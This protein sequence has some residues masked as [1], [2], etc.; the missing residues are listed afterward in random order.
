MMDLAMSMLM[1]RCARCHRRLLRRPPF[2]FFFFFAMLFPDMR[3]A[4]AKMRARPVRACAAARPPLAPPLIFTPSFLRLRHA[5]FIAFFLLA[6]AFTPASPRH[7]ARYIAR[8]PRR[9]PCNM[10]GGVMRAA[11][12]APKRCLPPRCERHDGCCLLF[13]AI[14]PAHAH[15]ALCAML[16]D[17]PVDV[18]RRVY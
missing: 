18:L 8:V 6:I 1:M 3:A 11:K 12:S 7:I 14:T 10:R 16:C 13:S 17:A 4:E 15:D 9:M 2:F 5:D